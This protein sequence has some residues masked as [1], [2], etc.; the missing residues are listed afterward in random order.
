MK[1]PASIGVS[2]KRDKRRN[3]DCDGHGH[4]ELMQETP[5]NAAHEKERDEDRDQG[6]A[7]GENGEPDFA[8]SF[9]G[10][11]KRRH[12]H[13]VLDVLHLH[14]GVVD[15]EAD[16]D[17]EPH[18]RQIVEAV[19]QRVHI[20]ANVP[21]IEIGTANPGMMVERRLRKNTNTT[22]TTSAMVSTSVNC[23]SATEARMVVVRS[24]IG[25]TL[26]LGRECCAQRRQLF[27]DAVHRVDDVGAGLLEHHQRDGALFRP[28]PQ[29]W[30]QPGLRP[31]GRCP[32][33][34]SERHS[35]KR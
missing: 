26:M 34:G 25:V 5:D 31:R 12:A 21:T 20:A 23:T 14:D 29:V 3:N 15:H 18:E 33:C 17:R 24:M 28:S 35:D 6:Q 7:D 11:P 1:R 9:V 2:E 10:C 22:A 8:R 30:C 4:G 13:V 16:G 19:A 27:L 32:G